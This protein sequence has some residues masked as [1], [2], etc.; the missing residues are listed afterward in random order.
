MFSSLM[1]LG[2]VFLLFLKFFVR[3]FT[4]VVVVLYVMVILEMKFFGYFRFS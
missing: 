1:M 3:V 2:F 4:L